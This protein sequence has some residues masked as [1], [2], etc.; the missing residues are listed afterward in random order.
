MTSPLKIYWHPD[1]MEDFTKFF[2]SIGGILSSVLVTI[3]FVKTV[4]YPFFSKLKILL[5]K[6]LF[7]A[8]TAD[9]EIFFPRVIV[10]SPLNMQITGCT[11]E[12]RGQKKET[13]FTSYHCKAEKFGSVEKIPVRGQFV[14]SHYL[15]KTSPDFLLKK[16]GTKEIL[17]RC[18]ILGSQEKIKQS[19]KNLE[20]DS[21]NIYKENINDVQKRNHL[22]QKSTEQYAN[23]IYSNVKVE[24]GEHTLIC[25]ITYKYRHLCIPIKKKVENR[26]PITITEEGLKSYKNVESI[27]TFLDDYLMSHGGSKDV[28]I[29]R[30]PQ[31][32]PTH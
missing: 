20:S 21:L 5:T 19:I 24:P 4:I 2:E 30:Y 28:P 17:I 29:I 8:L 16:D 7:F 10:Y 13:Q 9:G 1:T 11:F 6:D 22:V 31:V 12:L 26:I 14:P 25:K 32:T 3:Y 23:E 18:N 27:K 15:P